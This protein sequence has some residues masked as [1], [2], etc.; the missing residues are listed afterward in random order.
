MMTEGQKER[1]WRESIKSTE[2]R[3]AM[4]PPVLHVLYANSFL[5]SNLYVFAFLL[6]LMILTPHH[7][8]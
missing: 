3:V 2:E 5:P 7:T 1:G 4:L 8:A 6:S